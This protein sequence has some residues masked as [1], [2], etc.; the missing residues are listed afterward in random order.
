MRNF[1]ESVADIRK[2]TGIKEGGAEYL[3]FTTDMHQKPLVIFCRKAIAP[4]L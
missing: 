3:F 1:P 4:A 2:K